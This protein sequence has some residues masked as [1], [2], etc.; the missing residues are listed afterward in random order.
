MNQNNNNKEEIYT[1][2]TNLLFK[3]ICDKCKIELSDRLFLTC[4]NCDKKYH[5]DCCNI[6]SHR[7]YLME[8]EKR[9][10]WKCIICIESLKLLSAQNQS[11]SLESINDN[12]TYRNKHRVNI[13]TNNSFE[14]LTTEEEDDENEDDTRLTSN[15]C[16]N[17]SCPEFQLIDTSYKVEEMSKKI[18]A[19]TERLNSAD[20]EICNLLSEN[21]TLKSVI[22]NLENRIEHLMSICK[23]TPQKS[24]KKNKRKSLSKA[25]T[26]ETVRKCLNQNITDADINLDH[27][28]ITSRVTTQEH[29]MD[30]E[31]NINSNSISRSSNID[32]LKSNFRN[33]QTTKSKQNVANCSQS[34][35]VILSDGTGANLSE[36][37]LNELNG[38][39]KSIMNYC[40][41]GATFYDILKQYDSVTKTLQKD[42]TVVLHIRKYYSH[43]HKRA[44]FIKI[45]KKIMKEKNRNFNI[46]LCNFAYNTYDDEQIYKINEEL[47]R[48]SKWNKN[49]KY[50]ELENKFL[51]NNNKSNINVLANV[52][53]NFKGSSVLTYVTTT[54]EHVNFQKSKIKDNQS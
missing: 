24:G 42:D 33:E 5:L 45:L 20:N 46:I 26:T 32:P 28:E 3:M 53:D 1:V 25:T 47:S 34:R 11:T 22:S 6:S 49:V 51:K 2:T 7:F 54:E 36:K 40:K 27:D 10:A 17:R 9:C 43:H 14:F 41:R 38:N 39:K 8:H 50:L 15:T 48:I 19:L 37:L 30:K 21:Y 31:E 23:Q 29:C 35:V 52:I 16:L 18:L 4:A 13:S 44:S 12:I